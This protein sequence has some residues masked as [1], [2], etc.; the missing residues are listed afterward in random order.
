MTYSKNSLVNRCST[1][2]SSIYSR[3]IFEM[4]SSNCSRTYQIKIVRWSLSEEKKL[5]EQRLLFI[6]YD[7]H[8]IEVYDAFLTGEIN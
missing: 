3:V 5:I 7:K 6:C 2:Q 1:F 4:K 8:S